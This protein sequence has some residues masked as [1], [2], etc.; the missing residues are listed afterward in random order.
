MDVKSQYRIV[1]LFAMIMGGMSILLPNAVSAAACKCTTSIFNR[2]PN[3]SRVDSSG[4]ATAKTETVVS[5]P[6]SINVETM[7]SEALGKGIGSECQTL[8]D[9]GAILAIQRS[10]AQ[11]NLPD[12]LDIADDDSCNDS[13]LSEDFISGAV[14]QRPAKL[15]IQCVL[16]TQ[17]GTAGAKVPK[18]KCSDPGYVCL[19]NPLGEGRTDLRVI[20]GD[21]IK[22]VLTVLGSLTL[23]VFFA[24]GV[25]WLTSAGNQEK[26]KKGSNTMLYAVI[27]LFVIF[28]AYAIIN[29]VIKGLTGG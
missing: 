8:R 21:V 5:I 7:A 29:T 23:L 18:D 28:A 10:I 6:G 26:V 4:C 1:K 25:M 24:G 19:K 11:G 20:V 13:G 16:D 2:V 9:S 27:G 12:V 17:S 3:S 22:S 14:Q 15:I